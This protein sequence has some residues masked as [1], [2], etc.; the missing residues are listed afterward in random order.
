MKSLMFPTVTLRRFASVFFSS[1][2]WPLVG[3]V[4]VEMLNDTKTLAVS[5]ELGIGVRLGRRRPDRRLA[6]L[7]EVVSEGGEVLGVGVADPVVV[8]QPST[9]LLDQLVVGRVEDAVVYRS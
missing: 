8:E 2:S 6:P 7:G 3:D 5:E 9:A 4:D 1:S